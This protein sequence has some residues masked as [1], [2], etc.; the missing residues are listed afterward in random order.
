MKTPFHRPR[1][2]VLDFIPVHHDR[3]EPGCAVVE[4]NG[5]ERDRIECGCAVFLAHDDHR[6]F[7]PHPSGPDHTGTTEAGGIDNA[8]VDR[9]FR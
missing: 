6:R 4:R 7:L 9:Q 5:T 2:P 3:Q 8:I 1:H